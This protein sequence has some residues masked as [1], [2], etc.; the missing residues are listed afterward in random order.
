MLSIVWASLI[1]QLVKNPPPTPIFWPGEFHGHS[2]WSHKEL[3][4]TERLSLSLSS[5]ES[6]L[7]NPPLIWNFLSSL[8][9][10]YSFSRPPHF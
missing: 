4:T 5:I 2:L 10:T 8:D 3:D 9:K 6:F 1:A 7:F